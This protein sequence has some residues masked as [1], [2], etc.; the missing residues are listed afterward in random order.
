ML[1]EMGAV[2]LLCCPSDSDDLLSVAA[3]NT[4]IR[5]H[6]RRAA[7]LHRRSYRTADLRPDWKAV[8]P[9]RIGNTVRAGVSC[10][11]GRQLFQRVA[12]RPV[13]RGNWWLCADLVR[14]C[15]TVRPRGGVSIQY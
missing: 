12:G 10:T 15:C 9:R 2:W 3:E 1:H 8:W 13:R 7:G 11:S 14:R 4:G 5:F 6:F